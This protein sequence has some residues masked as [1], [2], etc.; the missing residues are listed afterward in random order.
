MRILAEWLLW[1][2][3]NSTYAERDAV[4]GTFLTALLC[5]FRKN[6]V[7]REAA[8]VGRVRTFIR[9]R[10]ADEITLDALAGVAGMNK[11]TFIRNYKQ[12]AG[13]TP[14]S[15]VGRNHAPS[16]V[17]FWISALGSKTRKGIQM[18]R[19]LV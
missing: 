5:E 17:P 8:L 11:Y 16:P 1:E 12:L 7:H 14:L 9:E 4:Q 19:A 2:E 13:A 15:D 6:A 3:R 10:L 18:G